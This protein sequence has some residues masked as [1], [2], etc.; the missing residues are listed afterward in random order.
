MA[1]FF[2]SACIVTIFWVSQK[3]VQQSITKSFVPFEL[4]STMSAYCH[5]DHL[6]LS[7]GRCYCCKTFLIPWRLFWEQATYAPKISFYVRRWFYLWN[8]LEITQ[9]IQLPSTMSGYC[10]REYL[11]LSFG[12][13]YCF[14][15][16]LIP[17]RIFWERAT[18]N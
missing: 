7:F 15:T 5:G 6:D 3:Y 16:F 14:K 13:W 9:L 17:W 11:D 4:P 8:S 2:F 10:Q 12:R 18:K 1:R